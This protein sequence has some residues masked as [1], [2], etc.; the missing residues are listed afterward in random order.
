MRSTELFFPPN[1]AMI[2][3]R[4]GEQDKAIDELVASIGKPLEPEYGELKLSPV[5]DPLRGDPRFEKLLEE[6][7]PK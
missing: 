6:A 2:Y 5:W 3:A 4:T 7:R 1:L